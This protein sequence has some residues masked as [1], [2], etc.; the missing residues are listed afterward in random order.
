MGS[1]RLIRR[2]VTGVPAQED[3]QR[4]R[5]PRLRRVQHFRPRNRP[6]NT[7]GGDADVRMRRG[8]HFGGCGS[9]RLGGSRR[10]ASSES[11]GAGQHCYGQGPEKNRRYQ[12]PFHISPLNP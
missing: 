11:L 5:P 8:W 10:W 2:I 7:D 9:Q 1:D 4:E 3:G 6:T 12:N